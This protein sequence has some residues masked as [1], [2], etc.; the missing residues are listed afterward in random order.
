MYGIYLPVDLGKTP[1]TPGKESPP[2]EV[3]KDEDAWSMILLRIAMEKSEDAKACFL[4]RC[5]ESAKEA[6]ERYEKQRERLE[7]LAKAALDWSNRMARAYRVRPRDWEENRFDITTE[8]DHARFDKAIAK[9]E[10]LTPAPQD[11]SG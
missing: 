6:L 1:M 4:E 9:F 8:R 11:K 10:A 2:T 7:K 5:A 3:D